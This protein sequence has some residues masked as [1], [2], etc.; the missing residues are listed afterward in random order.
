MGLSIRASFSGKKLS[1]WAGL[2]LPFIAPNQ[3]AALDWSDLSFAWRAK[4]CASDFGKSWSYSDYDSRIRARQKEILATA[5]SEGHSSQHLRGLMAA[6]GVSAVIRRKLHSQIKDYA[7]LA[8]LEIRGE[9]STPA[10]IREMR[11]VAMI[12]E[13][14][15]RQGIKDQRLSYKAAEDALA[16]CQD[17]HLIAENASGFITLVNSHVIAM[18]RSVKSKQYNQRVAALNLTSLPKNKDPR[19]AMNPINQSAVRSTATKL[20]KDNFLEDCATGNL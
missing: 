10:A 1:I 2:I 13:K 15:C 18:N 16:R 4:I 19:P 5:K 14:V 7:L 17:F 20:T 3:A 12:A 9:P 11:H 8:S 6:E